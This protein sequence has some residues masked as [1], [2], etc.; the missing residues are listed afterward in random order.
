MAHR[1]STPKT[2][3]ALVAYAKD[4]YRFEPEYPAP[5]CGPGRYHYQDR[6]LRYLCRRS[7][8]QSWRGHVLGGTTCSPR[9]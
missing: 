1:G 8:V 4:D 7:E 5:V 9:G 3:K 2:M 6:G